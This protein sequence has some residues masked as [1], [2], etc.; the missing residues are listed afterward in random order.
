M[1]Y[2]CIFSRVTLIGM[3]SI[4]EDGDGN[5]TGV[6]LPN[7]NLPEMDVSESEVIAEAFGQ[8]DEY[9]SGKRKEFDLPLDY[10]VTGFRRSVLEEIERIPYG[11]TRTYKDIAVAVGSP[12]AY[13]AVGAACGANPLPIIIPCHRVLP[14]GGGIGNYAGGEALKRRLLEHEKSML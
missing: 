8:M 6:Y 4:S 1:G 12:R 2:G 11:E 3:I 5:L 14:A 7:S 10:G 13:M 9:L